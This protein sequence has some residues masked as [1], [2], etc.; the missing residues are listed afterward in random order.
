M[1]RRQI[2]Y[3]H[4]P[5]D[6]VCLN[7]DETFS[8]VDRP[9]VFCTTRCANDAKLVRYARATAA[10][11]RIKKLDVALAVKVKFMHALSDIP[12]DQ[13]AR[14]LSPE[15]RAE[16]HR[17]D[18]GRC[19]KC[20]NL[21]NEIDHIEGDSNEPENLQLLCQLCHYRKT[22]W[23]AT[24]ITDEAKHADKRIRADKLVERIR[25]REPMRNCDNEKDW[26]SV[27]F[28]PTVRLRWTEMIDAR[29]TAFDT[30]MLAS[31]G[32]RSAS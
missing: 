17:R 28:H 26:E 6:F 13:Q 22:L 16:I 31:V 10:D 5:V 25:A 18:D 11:G 9:K 3:P 7:C 4:V 29:K 21:G 8:V 15:L 14:E 30:G 23:N 32:E 1:P 24:K 27:Y 19:V 2:K 12:Y 20:R